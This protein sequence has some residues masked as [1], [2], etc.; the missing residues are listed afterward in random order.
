K[1]RRS[2]VRTIIKSQV[3]FFP[4]RCR[5]IPEAAPIKHL[6]PEWCFCKIKHTASYS[7]AV[8]M[9]DLAMLPEYLTVFLNEFFL[10][11]F[12]C[13]EFIEIYFFLFPG[14]CNRFP[15]IYSL[16]TVTF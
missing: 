14:D 7:E 6:Q 12:I 8:D 9:N 10:S 5:I 15:H 3:N 2:R 11:D 4:I 1:G 13:K 16:I